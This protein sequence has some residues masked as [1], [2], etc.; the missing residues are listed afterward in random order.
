MDAR[1]RGRGRGR[2]TGEQ[3]GGAINM[4]PTE[5]AALI[6]EHVQAAVVATQT[7]QPTCKQ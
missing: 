3:G 2:G 7:G 6:N 4:T 5:L 1:G